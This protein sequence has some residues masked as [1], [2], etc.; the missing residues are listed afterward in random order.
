M[1]R[2]SICICSIYSEYKEISSAEI[3]SAIILSIISSPKKLDKMCTQF[4]LQE[5]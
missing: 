3:L 1:A 4:P 2:C 5:I